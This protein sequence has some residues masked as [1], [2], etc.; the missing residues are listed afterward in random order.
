MGPLIC[1]L[2][3][4]LVVAFFFVSSLLVRLLFL[5]FLGSAGI[6]F[7]CVCVCVVWLF[8]RW[9][10]V[11]VCFGL[12]GFFVSTAPIRA[13]QA[14]HANFLLVFALSFSFQDAI[15]ADW[16]LAFPVHSLAF[17]WN[18]SLFQWPPLEFSR[19]S[20]SLSL[21][22]RCCGYP[23]R[24]WVLLGFTAL[25]RVLL[26]FTGFYWVIVGFTGFYWVSLLYTEYYWVLL[27]FTGL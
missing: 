22:P 27:G 24:Q 12:V 10:F 13:H 5:W 7:L 26:G 6:F 15:K 23:R 19:L 8:R 21:S 1:I 14:F 16:L 18:G 17:P 9:C 4:C 11:F 3:D 25:Y 2:I 20:L